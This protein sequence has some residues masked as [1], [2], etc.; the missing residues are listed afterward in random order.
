MQTAQKVSHI[1]IGLLRITRR[2]VT[3]C[4]TDHRS[5]GD[6]KKYTYAPTSMQAFFTVVSSSSGSL[7]TA[8]VI[9][10]SLP[11]NKIL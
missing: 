7:H 2:K 5:A 10:S 11:I 6:S 8:H 3:T 9:L 4:T 1:P